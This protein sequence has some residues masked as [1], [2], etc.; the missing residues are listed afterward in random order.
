MNTTFRNALIALAIVVVG[1]AAAGAYLQFRDGESETASNGQ[2]AG[3]ED[4]GSSV[5]DGTATTKDVKF[6]ESVRIAGV[7]I[8]PVEIKED[9]RCPVDVQCIQAGTVRVRTMVTERGADDSMAAPV[10]FELGVPMTVG[11]DQITLVKVEPAK[12]SGAEI[13]P[14]DYVFTFTVVKGGGSEYYKG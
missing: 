2:V 12:N 1:G 11:V 7:K 13:L 3:A 9:S 14:G 5:P 8:N 4:D 6:N 10:A